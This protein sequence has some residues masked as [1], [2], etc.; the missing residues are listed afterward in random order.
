MPTL[1]VSEAIDQAL[2]FGWIDGKGVT[3]NEERYG[4][5]FCKRKPNGTWSKINKEKVERLIAS[6]QMTTAGLACIAAAKENG[7]WIILDEVEKLLVP[8]DL[9]KA[10]GLKLL[11]KFKAR[12]RSEQRFHLQNL[13]LAKTEKTRKSRITEIVKK[14]TDTA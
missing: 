14:L 3:I 5:Y 13:V 4:K 1:N 2:C 12:S 9:S 11:K 6:N 8:K 10:L 7:S